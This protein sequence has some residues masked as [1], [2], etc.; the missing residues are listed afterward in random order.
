MGDFVGNIP[1]VS[2]CMSTYRRPDLL[3]ATLTRIRQQSFADF[4]VVISDN[5]PQ[6]SAEPVVAAL[7]DARFRYFPNGTNLGMVSSFNK[8]IERSKGRFIVTITDDDPAYPD[9]V[10]T[11]YDLH[12]K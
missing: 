7:Q 10:Q 3:K 8:S 5:D 6:G 2:F 1:W 12:L 4:E 11:L 9:M